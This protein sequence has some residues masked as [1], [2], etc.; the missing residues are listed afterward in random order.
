M[1]E[2]AKY[3]LEI[4][5]MIDSI[6]SDPKLTPAQKRNAV[7]IVNQSIDAPKVM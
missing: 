5:V 4:K 7:Y 6:W 1:N 2:R 3:F